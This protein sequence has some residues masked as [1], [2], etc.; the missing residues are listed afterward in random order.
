V[1]HQR[2]HLRMC[3][4]H[5]PTCHT[6]HPAPGRLAHAHVQSS[7]A[8]M[9][10]W[11]VALAGTWMTAGTASCCI[12]SVGCARH[13]LPG[14]CPGT[15]ASCKLQFVTAGWSSRIAGHAVLCWH[16]YVALRVTG[17]PACLRL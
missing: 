9:L 8:C 16:L 7:S 4:C 13:V 1:L 15:L 5:W 14:W 12:G 17:L 10:L 6:L 2:S 11:C 3:R